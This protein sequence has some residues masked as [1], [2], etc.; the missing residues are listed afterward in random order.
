MDIRQYE[1]SLNSQIAGIS[2]G[3]EQKKEEIQ[4]KINE[5][6]DK[7]TAIHG[8]LSMAGTTLMGAMAG[9]KG[10]KAKLL[11]GVKNT[12]GKLNLKSGTQGGTEFV[13]G[14]ENFGASGGMPLNKALGGGVDTD[15]REFMGE[16]GFN[17]LPSVSNSSSASMSYNSAGSASRFGGDANEEQLRGDPSVGGAQGGG[18]GEFDQF[19]NKLTGTESDRQG[20]RVLAQQESE[21]QSGGFGAQPAGSIGG[22]DVKPITAPTVERGLPEDAPFETL[23]R[24]PPATEAELRSGTGIR[25][26]LGGDDYV[27][28]SI[29]GIPDN[30]GI[31]QASQSLALRMRGIAGGEAQ[32]LGDAIRGGAPTAY[33]NPAY[34]SVK[35]STTETEGGGAQPS[36]TNLPPTGEDAIVPAPKINAP[37]PSA[38]VP[39]VNAD[40]SA[41]ED[42]FRPITSIENDGDAGALDSGAGGMVKGA[43]KMIGMSDEAMAGVET[44][45]GIGGAVA[46]AVPFIGQLVGAGLLLGSVVREMTEKPDE[47]KD[48]PTEEMPDT[49]GYDATSITE[50]KGGGGGIY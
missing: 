6:W 26:G 9:I 22:S 38:P 7:V 32:Q 44:A 33:I 10:V 18:A 43:G 46:E 24:N 41:N 30:L 48:T 27:V 42:D 13:N 34:S 21:G 50:N 1:E 28:P 17:D 20:A 49:E 12:V 29:G 35:T 39:N 16:S 40:A 15:G 14:G 25:T 19:G 45:V 4:Q 31:S 11:S 36:V 2:A 3:V 8:E 5:R 47:E 37:E 23:F